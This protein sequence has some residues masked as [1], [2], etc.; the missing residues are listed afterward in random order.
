M[1]SYVPSSGK[2][3]QEMLEKIGVSAVEELYA[4]VPKKMLL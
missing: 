2:E 4:A 3:R 1:G